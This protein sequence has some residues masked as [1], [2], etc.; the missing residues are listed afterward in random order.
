[1]LWSVS[2]IGVMNLVS[3]NASKTQACLFS[4]KKRPFNHKPSFRE[5]LVPI[6]D[7]LELLGVELTSNLN[8]GSYIESKAKVAA[9]KLGILSKVRQ[10]FTPE[11]LLLLYQAQVR[12]CMEYCCHLWDGSA[13]YQLDALDSIER[14]AKRLVGSDQLFDSK[15][16]S[17]EHRRRVA[18]LTVFYRLHFG[19]C[20][21]ELHDLIPPS[22]FH[23]RT[24][25]RTDKCHPFTVDIPHFRTKRFASTFLVRTAKEWNSLPSSVF[26]D[27]YNLGIFKKRVNRWIIAKRAPS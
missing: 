4:A 6:S 9:K 5:I 22:P 7:H 12:S 14:R 1:M 25:R 2:L 11:Q 17:L 19:E 3:F 13:K 10:Y 26:P 21:Q 27:H 16:Y 15:L 23:L 20:A 8:F 24:S 18:S